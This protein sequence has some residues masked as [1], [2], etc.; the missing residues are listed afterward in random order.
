MAKEYIYIPIGSGEMQEY[1]ENL[2]KAWKIPVNQILANKV[3]SGVG[4][5]MY[6]W[7]NQCLSKLNPA[8]TLYIVTHGTGAADGKYI[9]A[10]RSTS[11]NKQKKIYVN[12]REEWQGGE[13]KTYTPQQLATTLVK[14]GL[15]ANFVNLHVCACGSGYDGEKLRPWAQRLRQAMGGTH[16][17]I[18][19]T[20]YR[21]W[22][23]C[24]PGKVCI[25]VGTQFYPLEERAVTFS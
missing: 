9:G 14:E 13:W 24:S 4:K 19:V 23:S 3:T 17:N 18:Q 25:K 1:A 8:D 20:G 11:D 10:E 2:A 22:F 12:G 6:R 15:P 21:G 16:K 7:V 5:A